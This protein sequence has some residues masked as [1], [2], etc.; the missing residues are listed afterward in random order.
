MSTKIRSQ[1]HQNQ[2]PGALTT[3]PAKKATTARRKGSD[4]CRAHRHHTPHR[5]TADECAKELSQ[6]ILT[7]EGGS[8]YQIYD[9]LRR[10]ANPEINGFG[11]VKQ[12]ELLRRCME[13]GVRTYIE[14]E[15][16][17]AKRVSLLH[18]SMIYH[19]IKEELAFNTEEEIWVILLNVRAN[20]IG[21][22]LCRTRRTFRR[23]SRYSRYPPQGHP[24]LRKC[25]R[26]GTQPPQR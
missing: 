23:Y 15:T 7:R 4:R 26:S 10:R 21:K 11:P 9:M 12:T 14:K 2:R 16:S 3:D 25:Y 5:H 13:L 1:S 17:D 6:E 22:F 8:L 20:P 18:S 19:Y 24:I